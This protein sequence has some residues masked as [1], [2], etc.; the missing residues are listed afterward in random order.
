MS[1]P[2]DAGPPNR[3]PR[4]VITVLCG[5]AMGVSD[6]IPGVSGGTIALILGIY[7]RFIGSLAAVLTGL[8]RWR[9]RPS[10]LAAL[11][12]LRFLVP[13]G[14]GMGVALVAA[15]KLLVGDTHHLAEV[16]DPAELHAGMAALPGLLVNPRRA[17]LVFAF[18]FGLVLASIPEPW[19]R[20]R[21]R[22][23]WDPVV[24][25]V[26]A[27]AAATV[28]LS[29]AAAGSTHP[30]VVIGA[31]A[32]AI[33]VMLLPGISGS[34]ALLMVGMYQPVAES[35]SAAL[36]GSRPG[37]VVVAGFLVGMGL[38]LAVFV[39]LLR[40]ALR[41]HHDRIMPLLSGLMAGSLAAL[42]PWKTH[43]LPQAIDVLGPMGLRAPHGAW[44]WPVACAVAGAAIILAARRWVRGERG[45]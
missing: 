23:W 18:F 31:G 41:R 30:L 28:A 42:W 22:R 26:G 9:D 20:C 27:C 34:L 1:D 16:I 21:S 2:G 13:L 39:P 33:S 8:R 4:T 3:P 10:R 25:V 43:Y 17:P 19:T 15:M 38:G 37:M 11:D 7:E 5:L 6:A 14:L 24:A 12:G 45:P 36:H 40:F 44:W 29:P 32:L 35:V